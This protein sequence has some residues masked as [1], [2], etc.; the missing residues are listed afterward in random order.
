[1][2]KKYKHLF[3][4]L[5]RTLWDFDS[6]ARIAFREIFALHEL[7]GKGVGDVGEFQAVYNRHNEM[8]WAQ[9]RE[10]KIRKEELR[11]TRFLLTLREFGIDDPDLAVA[12]GD[13]YIRIS[14]LRVA[15]FPHAREILGYVR[16]K[17][18]VHM[19]T[20]GFSEVQQVKLRSSGLG[21]YFRTIITSEEAGHKKP[22]KRIFDYALNKTGA[23]PEESIMIGDDPD[24]DILGA[25]EAGMDQVLFDPA[26]KHSRN[27]STHYI[28]NLN[29]L[30]KI[31]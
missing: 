10:G 2:R 26:G 28:R 22:D 9:Y 4:D 1:M 12:I 15:L 14:P 16:E 8:L 11:S 20:N 7:G 24:V 29:E 19:I 21:E 17:Y 13:E 25:R 23:K 27:G 6:S 31:F 5:D 30:R 3:F 18:P